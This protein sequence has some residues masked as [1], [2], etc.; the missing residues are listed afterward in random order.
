MALHG[1]FA[2]YKP[3]G[4][5]WPRVRDAVETRLLAG[6]NS[7]QQ[8]PPRQHVRFLPG[9]V[10]GEADKELTL[11]P[12]YLP[13]LADHLLVK[14]PRFPRLK[15][16]AGHRLDVKSSGVFGLHCSWSVWQSHR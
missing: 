8:R 9:F 7:L 14:G 16:G 11:V 10:E 2:V 5:A 13:V 3:A 15:V 1:L 12:T 6:L 4:V